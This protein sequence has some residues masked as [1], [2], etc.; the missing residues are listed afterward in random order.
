MCQQDELVVQFVSRFCAGLGGYD[1]GGY[2][3]SDKRQS[4]QEVMH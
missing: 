3:H 4:N 1:R 2:Y